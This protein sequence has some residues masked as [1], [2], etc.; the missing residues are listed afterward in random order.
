MHDTQEN[1]SIANIL[2]GK[3]WARRTAFHYRKNVQQK[4]NETKYYLQY[5]QKTH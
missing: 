1:P 5:E 3:A 2:F 4:S